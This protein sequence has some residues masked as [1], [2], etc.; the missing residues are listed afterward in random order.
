[1]AFEGRNLV[2]I[3]QDDRGEALYILKGNRLTE[4]AR[5]GRELLSFDY[6]LPKIRGDLVLFRGTNH[7]KQKVVYVVEGGI[8]RPL[9]TQGDIVKTDKGPA[10]VDYQNQDALFYGSPGI[11]PSGEIIQQATLIHPESGDLI[12]VGLLKFVKEQR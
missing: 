12:G 5:A 3:A 4:L 10:K 7:K 11:G 8:L 2:F 9:I 1:M 6:F